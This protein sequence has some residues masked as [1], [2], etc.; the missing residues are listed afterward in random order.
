MV[1]K[2]E[3]S[4]R[5]DTLT[6]STQKL[7]LMGEGSLSTY[8]VIHLTPPLTCSQ[9]E[10][11]KR[12]QRERRKRGNKWVEAQ[13]KPLSGFKLETSNFDTMLEWTH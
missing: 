10:R 1:S 13:I 6:S 3:V 4:V 8:T 2:P 12:S 11:R 9:R 7:K 5:V